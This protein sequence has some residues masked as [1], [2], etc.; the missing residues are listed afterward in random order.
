MKDNQ[1]LAGKCGVCR[2]HDAC[3]FP[4]LVGYDTFGRSTR[5]TFLWGMCSD[6]AIAI[7]KLPE[8]K[9]PSAWLPTMQPVKDKHE[10]LYTSMS[11][12]VEWELIYTPFSSERGQKILK[13]PQLKNGVLPPPPIEPL[14]VTRVSAKEL[15]DLQ[16]EWGVVIPQGTMPS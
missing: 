10:A 16:E 15:Q 7:R 4:E 11:P 2:T 13:H 1:S 8:D 14:P 12:I 6:H 3:A 5:R 9:F